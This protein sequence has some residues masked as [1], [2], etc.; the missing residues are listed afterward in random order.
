M[1]YTSPVATDPETPDQWQEVVDQSAAL[2]HV[3]EIVAN[4]HSTR[5]LPCFA[6]Q[7]AV[8]RFLHASI[9]VDH[10]RY[11]LDRG[12]ELGYLPQDNVVEQIVTEAMSPEKGRI[13]RSL[14]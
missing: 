10:C 6:D 8:R 4:V 1:A 11:M 9:D 3:K 5:D 13:P 14:P 7:T 2:L 12:R